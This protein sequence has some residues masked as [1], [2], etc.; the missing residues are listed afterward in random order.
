MVEQSL[1]LTRKPSKSLE[2]PQPKTSSQGPNSNPSSK[3]L[4][5]RRLRVEQ[6]ELSLVPRIGIRHSALSLAKICWKH[7]ALSFVQAQDCTSESMTAKNEVPARITFA[8]AKNHKSECIHRILWA[9]FPTALTDNDSFENSSNKTL[10][11][12]VYHSTNLFLACVA[13]SVSHCDHHDSVH[14][15]RKKTAKQAYSNNNNIAI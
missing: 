15:L 3:T 12:W 7:A 1:G 2:N 11:N 4:K 9:A 8:E 13:Q 10:R 6:F 5:A 14:V